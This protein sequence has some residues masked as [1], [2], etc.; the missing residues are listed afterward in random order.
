MSVNEEELCMCTKCKDIMSLEHF[1]TNRIRTSF[2]SLCYRCRKAGKQTFATPLTDAKYDENKKRKIC[3]TCNRP[4][5]MRDY[6]SKIFETETKR[7]IMCRTKVGLLICDHGIPERTCCVCNVL[8][9][10]HGLNTDPRMDYYD[11]H[12]R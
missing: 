12:A 10:W 11:D 7:C 4:K 2:T 3:V 5:P 8:L 9:N 6:V 1:R